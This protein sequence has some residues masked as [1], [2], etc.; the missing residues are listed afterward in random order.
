MK[1]LE[2]MPS[3]VYQAPFNTKEGEWETIDLNFSAF[4]ASAMGRELPGAPDIDPRQVAS[5]GFV[6]SKF[7]A[8]GTE[9]PSFREG[10][11]SLAV[12]EIAAFRE[13]RDWAAKPNA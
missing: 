12:K 13:F 1:S 3:V 4:V 8:N 6:L 7:E 9:N 2:A 10:P 5:I 11:F